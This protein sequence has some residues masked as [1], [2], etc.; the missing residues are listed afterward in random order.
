MYKTWTKATKVAALAAAF[1]VS[2]VVGAAA[3]DFTPGVIYDVGSKFD[4]SFNEAAYNGL[5]MFMEETGITAVRE[6]EVQQEAQ[7]EQ[8]MRNFA[9]RGVDHIVVAGFTQAQPLSKVA[10]EFPDV[11]FTLIDAV[12]DLPNVQSILFKEEEGSYLVG[13]LA[14]MASKSGKVG[15]IGGMDIPLISAFGCGYKQG[16]VSVNADVDVSQNMVGSTPAA[17]SDPIKASELAR[18]QMDSGVDVIFAA[19]GGSGEGAATAA[20]DRGNLFIGV[21]SNQNYLFPG[22]V[23]TSMLKRVDV[24]TYQTF[25]ESMEGT[26]KPGVVVYGVAEDGVGWALDEHNAPLITA[27]MKAAVEK[28]RMDIISGAIDVHDYRSNNACNL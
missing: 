22:K 17:W 16:A 25:K 12:V 13:M 2:A 28:A 9:R 20:V 7:R 6:F 5:K 23:L 11:K 15:F 24:A 4:K 19:A 18:S 1:S 8:A 26:W 14:A 21:D 27:D 3:D 10:A